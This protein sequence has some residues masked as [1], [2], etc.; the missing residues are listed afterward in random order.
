MKIIQ[1]ENTKVEIDERKIL[2]MK[3]SVCAIESTS[4]LI[5][6]KKEAQKLSKKVSKSADIMRKQRYMEAINDD[7]YLYLRNYYD[8]FSAFELMKILLNK[9]KERYINKEQD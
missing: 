9:I 6:N 5:R 8:S 4:I 2:K 7:D 3:E 1:F